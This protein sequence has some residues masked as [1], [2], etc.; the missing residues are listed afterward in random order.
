MKSKAPETL[1]VAIDDGY[2]QTK[3]YGMDPSGNGIVRNVFRTSVRSG[4]Y[5]LRS[6]G[7]EGA[8]DSY[9]T[10]EGDEFT[11]SDKIEAENTQF[12]G[13][14]TSTM[15]RTLV[16][17]GL[18]AA[19]YAGKSIDLITGLP[20]R[21]YFGSDGINQEHIDAKR[22]NLLKGVSRVSSDEPLAV[23][24][25]IDVGCQAVAAWFDHT[26]DDE[27]NMRAQAKGRV[28]IV[29]VGGRTTDIAVVVNGKS[30][31]DSLSGTNNVGVLDVYKALQDAVHGRFKIRDNIPLEALDAAVRTGTIELWGKEHDV[32]DLAT[33]ARQNVES[34]IQREI[35]RKIGGAMATLSA[36]VFVGG[37]SAL[38]RTIADR[39]PNGVMSEDPEFANARGL[40]KFAK[41]RA[42]A[43]EK[44]A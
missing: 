34:R 4:R 22:R 10:E 19:G 16:H 41:L 40:F 1:L 36:V 13:F 26:F 15:N 30:I 43:A 38:Y 11:V 32:R 28:A 25:S 6:I 27:L 39:F 20:V 35:D 7:G 42:R 14:H 29:D 9:K 37:G 23:I 33:E 17:H 8:I 24:S 31:D 2:A 18:A 5:G 12:D 3:V 44:A 21:D